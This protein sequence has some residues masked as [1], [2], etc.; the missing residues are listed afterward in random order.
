[1]YFL[2]FGSCG[3]S[4]SYPVDLILCHDH[5]TA[6]L[7]EQLSKIFQCNYLID[8]HEHALTQNQPPSGSWKKYIWKLRR[9]YVNNIQKKYFPKA[10][11]L[12][13]VSEG[14][15]IS[16]QKEYALASK[17]TVIRSMPFY[18][19]SPF[20]PLEKGRP[21]K[22]LYHG[23]LSPD[24]GLE[25]CIQAMAFCD[26]RFSLTLRGSG[27][28][29]PHYHTLLL[30]LASKSPACDR[31]YFEPPV[32]FDH[33]ISEASLFDI[34]LFIPHHH[35]LQQLHALP[36]K[37]FEYIMAGLMLAVSDLP[38]IAHL[39]HHHDLGLLLPESSPQKIAYALNHLSEEVINRHK[40]NA[41][42]AA[43][44]LCWE[45]EAEKLKSVLSKV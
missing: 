41:L 11:A 2:L 34:G 14:I 39:V 33:I 21:I 5:Y 7:A 40:Q 45:K 26:E 24:R 16:L 18:T 6:P 9:R 10:Q 35:T 44:A 17:P 22:L 28:W 27:D 38:D 37:F 4:S 32:P 12:T 42:R 29:D 31:I 36:N 1:M 30:K 20:R 23:N 3:H 43:K 25:E 8:V 13:T 19:A 15:A